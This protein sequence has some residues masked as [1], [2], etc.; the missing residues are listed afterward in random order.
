MYVTPNNW[1]DR[2]TKSEIQQ[3]LNEYYDIDLRSQAGIL[4]ATAKRKNVKWSNKTSLSISFIVYSS[5][6][7][8]ADIRTSGGSLN[9]QNI[10]GEVTGRTSGGSITVKIFQRI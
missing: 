6:Q 8:N 10:E 2:K 9:V 5:N 1:G 7:V 3:I 4:T